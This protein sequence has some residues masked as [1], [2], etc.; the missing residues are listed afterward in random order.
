MSD[1]ENSNACIDNRNTP[2]QLT[3][4]AAADETVYVVLDVIGS[5]FYRFDATITIN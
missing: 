1:F 2:G 3:Y 5:D 4:T